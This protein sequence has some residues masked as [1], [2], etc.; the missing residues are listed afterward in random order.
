MTMNG[1]GSVFEKLLQV[2]DEVART[3]VL[4]VRMVGSNQNGN[5]F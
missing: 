3:R 1:A 2:R 4:A 5:I